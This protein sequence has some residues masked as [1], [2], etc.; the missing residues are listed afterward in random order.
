MKEITEDSVTLEE[1]ITDINYL[2]FYARPDLPVDPD[3]QIPN[4]RLALDDET[5]PPS[6]TITYHDYDRALKIQQTPV[7]PENQ[8]DLIEAACQIKNLDRPQLEVLFLHLIQDGEL[9]D[10][11]EKVLSPHSSYEPYRYNQVLPYVHR[12]IDCGLVNVLNR[13]TL[14]PAQWM[15]EKMMMSDDPNLIH[16]V[17]SWWMTYRKCQEILIEW[18]EQGQLDLLKNYLR[19]VKVRRDVFGNF[20]ALSNKLLEAATDDVEFQYIMVKQ[21]MITKKHLAKH[22][23]DHEKWS[24]LRELL[25]DPDF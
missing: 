20:F 7:T 9:V 5:V 3:D 11:I 17:Q 10:P 13:F 25:Q 16:Q 22:L 1:L 19:K 12:A 18:V 6:K 8:F 15:I 21:G 2:N 23:L 4:K 14:F 24:D